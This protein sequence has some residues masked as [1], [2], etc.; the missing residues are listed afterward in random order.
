MAES[1]A[2]LDEMSLSSVVV[3]LLHLESDIQHT[4]GKEPIGD[5]AEVAHKVSGVLEASVMAR[6]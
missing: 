6:H 2:S 4:Q 3:Q 5:D 1:E